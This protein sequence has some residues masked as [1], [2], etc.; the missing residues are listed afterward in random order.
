MS[1][2]DPARRD[3]IVRAQLAAV[4]SV[5]ESANVLGRAE[6][7]R[8]V[9]AAIEHAASAPGA[10]LGPDEQV[11]F[12]LTAVGECAL[13]QARA[14]RVDRDMLVLR[15]NQLPREQQTAYSLRVESRMAD[16]Q[17]AEVMGIS[18]DAVVMLI[19][20]ALMSLAGA[21]DGQHV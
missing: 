5:A 4:A 16:W 21:G 15:I 14:A 2:R 20:K 10:L 13:Y 6:A 18:E 12:R 8:L 17:I 7:V 1:E 3:L 11:L 19:L 9:C